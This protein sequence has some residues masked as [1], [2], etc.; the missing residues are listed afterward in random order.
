A[1]D[2][3]AVR[4]CRATATRFHEEKTMITQLTSQHNCWRSRARSRHSACAS[5]MLQWTRAVRPLTTLLWTMFMMLMF[6]PTA[7]ADTVAVPADT[8]AGAITHLTLG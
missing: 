3:E 7:R 4:Q 1:R 2:G 5:G 6:V 8:V